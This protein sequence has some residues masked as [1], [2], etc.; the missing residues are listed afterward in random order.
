MTLAPDSVGYLFLN[1]R[2]VVPLVVRVVLDRIPFLVPAAVDLDNDLLRP[3]VVVVIFFPD[4]PPTNGVACS[5][6]PV[7]EESG[8]RGDGL[9]EARRLVDSFRAPAVY[10]KNRLFST[11]CR[12]DVDKM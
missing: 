11:P 3:F 7:F 1:V 10:V 9:E 4:N 6:V 12:S 8:S 5:L 2:P